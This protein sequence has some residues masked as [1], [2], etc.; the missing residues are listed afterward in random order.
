MENNPSFGSPASASPWVRR[1]E[2]TFETLPIHVVDLGKAKRKAIKQLKKGGGELHQA[3]ID[4]LSDIEST[5]GK[6]AVGKTVLPVVVII[7]KKAKKRGL[8]PLF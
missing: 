1:T 5:L 4:A 6:D 7:E 2:A 3:V 8:I